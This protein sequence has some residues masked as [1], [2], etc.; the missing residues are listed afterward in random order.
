MFVHNSTTIHWTMSWFLVHKPAFRSTPGKFCR[1]LSNHITRGQCGASET[2]CRCICFQIISKDDHH[3]WQARH[4]TIGGSAGLIP[5]PEL[6]E[7]RIAC[8][9]VDKTKH[10]QGKLHANSLVLSSVEN[11]LLFMESV[12]DNPNPFLLCLR[13]FS[14]W[15][16]FLCCVY[17]VLFVLLFN[18]TSCHWSKISWHDIWFIVFMSH[19]SLHYHSLSLCVAVCLH[20]A[21]VW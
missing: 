12:E 15:F 11:S 4:D 17:N 18:I 5:S 7:W 14:Y 21:K 6:Q 8:Q 20:R 2:F 10:E 16:P 9:T 3:W 13:V 1:F 19:L